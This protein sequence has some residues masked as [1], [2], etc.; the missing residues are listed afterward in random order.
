MCLKRSLKAWDIECASGRPRIA[1]GEDGDDLPR[2]PKP[3][4][5]L[6]IDPSFHCALGPF[7]RRLV[8]SDLGQIVF[9]FG[10]IDPASDARLHTVRR[11]DPSLRPEATMLEFDSAKTA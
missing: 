7:V 5:L 4:S 11:S 3:G 9:V 10:R 6:L 1:G 8:P 2:D